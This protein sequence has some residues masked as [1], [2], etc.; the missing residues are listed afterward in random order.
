M[1]LNF[2]KHLYM[3][4]MSVC[5]ALSLMSIGQTGNTYICLNFH[6]ISN[7]NIDL[8]FDRI[9]MY[10]YDHMRVYKALYYAFLNK[11]TLKIDQIKYR[12]ALRIN[13]LPWDQSEKCHIS[14]TNDFLK[15][16]LI[17]IAKKTEF[18][19]FLIK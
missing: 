17:S 7:S 16:C 2:H 13:E 14:I 18:I 6:R 19:Y 4:C 15:F 1:L 3:Y 9:L 12:K 8:G 5:V 11:T 10:I